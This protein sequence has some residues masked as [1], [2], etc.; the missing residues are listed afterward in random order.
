MIY[1]QQATNYVRQVKLRSVSSETY[2][3]ARACKYQY[4][5]IKKI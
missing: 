5:P 2:V 3:G 1:F 4:G